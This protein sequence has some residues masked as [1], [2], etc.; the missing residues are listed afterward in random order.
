MF[1]IIK[2][3]SVFLLFAAFLR[4][5][6]GSSSGLELWPNEKITREAGE[7]TEFLPVIKAG[8]NGGVYITGD[9][10]KIEDKKVEM[11]DLPAVLAKLRKKYNTISYFRE[12]VYAEPRGKYLRHIHEILDKL[13]KAG[14]AIRMADNYLNQY[15]EVTNFVI[16]IGP[17]RFRIGADKGRLLVY[18]FTPKGEKKMKVYTRDVSGPEAW[19]NCARNFA[20]IFHSNRLPAM[21]QHNRDIAFTA[22]E[23]KMS[24]VHIRIVIDGKHEWRAC[25][26]IDEVPENIQSF[27]EDC[28][29]IGKMY[30]PK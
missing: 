21:E 8:K 17:G 11:K 15:G 6:T 20:M 16:Y 9:P 18:A 29:V 2:F 25:Y 3:S 27:M 12:G 1:K 24:S 22:D 14:F 28:R 10:M 19:K 4:A 23:M 5:D 30:L 13:E 7:K 26:S